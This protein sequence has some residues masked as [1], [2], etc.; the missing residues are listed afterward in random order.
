MRKDL[1][2][3]S[4]NF[5]LVL[6]GRAILEQSRSKPQVCKSLADQFFSINIFPSLNESAVWSS[7]R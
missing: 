6:K 7:G 4:W 5:V 2:V 1:G 3:R